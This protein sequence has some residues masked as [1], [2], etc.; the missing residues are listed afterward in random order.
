MVDG[1]AGKKIGSIWEYIV[2]MVLRGEV[3]FIC[4]CYENKILDNCFLL[5]ASFLVVNLTFGTA[6][7]RKV[8]GDEDRIDQC[9]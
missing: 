8:G 5:R 3:I 4:W 7:S 6:Q 2:K 1:K 9:G